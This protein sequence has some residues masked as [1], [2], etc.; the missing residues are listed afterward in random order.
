MKKVKPK[1]V[2]KRKYSPEEPEENIHKNRPRTPSGQVIS[3]SVGALKNKI[4]NNISR[5]VERSSPLSEHVEE[6][7]VCAINR[8]S[9]NITD[10]VN[11]SVSVNCDQDQRSASACDVLREAY[12]SVYQTTNSHP[13]MRSLLSEMPGNDNTPNRS[14]ELLSSEKTVQ[15]QV[16]QV[17]DIKEQ[18]VGEDYSIQPGR[19][20]PNTMDVRTVVTLLEELKI[21]FKNQIEEHMSNRYPD[22]TDMMMKVNQ[23]AGELRIC[24]AKERILIDTIS[25]MAD[26]IT[27][28]QTKIEVQ[29]VNKAKRMFIISGLTTSTKNHIRKQQVKNF[30]YECVT[31]QIEVEDTFVIGGYKGTEIVVTVATVSQKDAVFQQ[32]SKLKGME[33]EQGKPFYI[34]Q[35]N[36]Q[37]QQEKKR[38]GQMIADQVTQL[39]SAQ[40][41]EV[42]TFRNK[43]YVGEEEY[44]KKITPPD[45]TKVLRM[46]LTKL[47][48][49]MGLDTPCGP[50][51]R[52]GD[53]YFTAYVLGVVNIEQVQDF[54]M[55]IKLNH[56]EARHIVCAWNMLGEKWYELQDYCDDG[57]HGVGAAIL[58][59]MQFNNLEQAAIYVVRNC[60]QKLKENRIPTYVAAIKEA[61]KTSPMNPIT[62]QP[63]NFKEDSSAFSRYSD[64]PNSPTYAGVT[65]DGPNADFPPLRISQDQDT[66]SNQ[67]QKYVFNRKRGNRYA[68]GRG[69]SGRGRGRGRGGG[70]S[71]EWERK[72]KNNNQPRKKYT[73]PTE[74]EVLNSFKFAAPE[75]V[76]MDIQ[77]DNA[78]VD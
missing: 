5:H 73:P 53:N 44:V 21:D 70:R 75:T 2:N 4:E 38:R 3:V 66:R 14:I 11:T 31:D 22:Q 27:E 46:P 77:D 40:Q 30:L 57:D 68:A 26:K 25:G 78:D 12:Q 33:N 34:R 58:Q 29:E 67:N 1:R 74:E 10:C 72:E 15:L 54:Y 47:N 35:Y 36:T 19:P 65:K 28:L 76:N 69:R 62:K 71:Q 17:V 49:I 39:D 60:G 61:I 13:L 32:K 59:R 45:P 50:T 41:V 37:Q 23:M 43:T 18:A 63:Y 8:N 16:E 55:K 20:N 56:A 48:N 42:S 52:A 64:H 24:E 51:V 6:D 9:V 7:S